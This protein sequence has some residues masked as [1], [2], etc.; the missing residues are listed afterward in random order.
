MYTQTYV[1]VSQMRSCGE[2]SN[3]NVVLG[4]HLY[5]SE[6]YPFTL[7]TSSNG[8]MELPLLHQIMDKNVAKISGKDVNTA[9]GCSC[10]K[11]QSVCYS[12]LSQL[13]FGFEICGSGY[14]KKNFLVGYEH[15]TCTVFLMQEKQEDVVCLENCI[16]PSS[17]IDWAESLREAKSWGLLLDLY[18]E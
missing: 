16:F 8:R 12:R 5:F 6:L 10:K 3:Y 14:R 15:P 4:S 11:R 9:L 18:F 2:W 13:F 7:V 17:R 1:Q